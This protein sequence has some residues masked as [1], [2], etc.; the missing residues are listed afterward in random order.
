MN[1]MHVCCANGHVGAM[2]RNT[3]VQRGGLAMV[4]VVTTWKAGGGL[5]PAT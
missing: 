3:Y 2:Q 1:G 4:A 5:V